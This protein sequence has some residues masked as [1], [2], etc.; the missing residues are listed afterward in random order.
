MR[1]GEITG[2]QWD[3]V[4]VSEQSIAEGD[5]WL[6]I[7]REL[8]R[9]EADALKA[10]DQKDVIYVFPH[11]LPGT[12]TRLVLKTPKTRSSVRKIW[13]PKT[14][15]ELILRWKREQEKIKEH[16]GE[17]FVDYGL[18]L[19]QDNGRPLQNYKVLF[20]KF[21]KKHNLPN[22]VFHSLRHSSTTYKPKLNNGDIKATQG[23]TGHSQPEMVTKV[24][25]HILDE[26]RK[27]NAERFEEAF[28][29]PKENKSDLESLMSLLE[30]NPDLLNQLKAKL[31]D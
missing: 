23:D 15:A 22:V 24:Y 12:K 18:V 29:S 3:H 16:I 20:D 5:S 14:V 26:D 2:L 31:S 25:A 28:Y 9:V 11:L 27:V 6:Q 4:N 7:D 21:K 10:L 19:T 13:I 8:T 17:Y 30:K 1:A